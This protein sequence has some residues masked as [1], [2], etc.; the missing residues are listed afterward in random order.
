MGVLKDFD[1]TTVNHSQTVQSSNPNCV[2]RPGL[3]YSGFCKNKEC[4]SADKSVVMNRGIGSFLVNEDIMGDLIKC[5]GCGK[6]FDMTSVNLYRCKA[7]VTVLD[8][9]EDVEKYHPKGEA[10]V[11]IG[12]K[13]GTNLSAS[14]LLQVETSLDGQKCLLQ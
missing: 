2:I 9:N 8:H 10:I 12:S 7:V 13:K 11:K 6:A 1:C 3:S 4:A 14:A 5:P